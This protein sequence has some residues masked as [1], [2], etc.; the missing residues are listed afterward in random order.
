MKKGRSSRKTS[1]TPR[2]S[3]L[4]SNSKAS[5]KSL[6]K[7]EGPQIS[8][9]ESHA[10]GRRRSTNV[11]TYCESGRLYYDLYVK[12]GLDS[13]LLRPGNLSHRDAI[14]S[15]GPLS[16]IAHSS[17]VAC[18]GEPSGRPYMNKGSLE[19]HTKKPSSL[20]K[21][22]KKPSKRSD[23][24]APHLE[25]TT[26]NVRREASLNAAAKVNML[27]ES[28]KDNRLK[29]K[30]LPAISF[31]EEVQ[32][33]VS[34]VDESQVILP[35]K[36]RTSNS[37]HGRISDPGPTNSPP[38]KR[39][40]GLNAMAIISAF[41]KSPKSTPSL[42]K[43]RQKRTPTAKSTSPSL[44]SA[45][46]SEKVDHLIIPT[47]PKDTVVE[48]VTS[49]S[50]DT[51]CS[52]AALPTLAPTSESAAEAVI[53]TVERFQSQKVISYGPKCIG[54]E[55]VSRQ[56]FHVPPQTQS[57][58]DPPPT[59]G[60][61]CHHILAPSY[62]ST[63]RHASPCPSTSSGLVHPNNSAVVLPQTCLNSPPRTNI[64]S[65]DF[66]NFLPCH[67]YLHA[68]SHP[69]T[70]QPHA[71]FMSPTLFHPLTASPFHFLHAPPFGAA[72]VHHLTHQMPANYML[73]MSVSPVFNTFSHGNFGGCVTPRAV[74]S[75]Q[76]VHPSLMIEQTDSQASCTLARDQPGRV[77]R[78]VS[79]IPELITEDLP[80]PVVTSQMKKTPIKRVSAEKTQAPCLWT[81]EGKPH[82]RLVFI[83]PD[84]PPVMRLCYPSM[85]HQKD[86]M[87]VCPG[88]NVLLCSGPDRHSAPHVAKVTAL[89]TSPETGTKMMAL[90]W[91][92]RPESLTPPRRN[93][94]IEC[95]LFA[96]RHCDV[97]PVDCIDDR[98]YVLSSS[99]YARFMALAKYKQEARVHRRPAA[100][101]PQSPSK[102]PHGSTSLSNT[103][104][105]YSEFPE[106]ASSSNVFLCRAW[107]DFRSR[108]VV[109]HLNSS[110]SKQLQPANNAVFAGTA[111]STVHTA[112]SRCRSPS[113]IMP[114][115][116]TQE[117]PL[118]GEDC[119]SSVLT[120]PISN[121]RPVLD[122][123]ADLSVNWGDH[124]EQI[125]LALGGP[126]SPINTNTSTT[127]TPHVFLSTSTS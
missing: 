53:P 13:S 68:F 124:G 59:S 72:Y 19:K 76:P 119:D 35:P 75:A 37:H 123:T 83:K 105:D 121:G 65:A 117:I 114:P 91:Y 55:N 74:I 107:Y 64:L 98:A 126:Q 110:A 118:E 104:C 45:T 29:R 93:G 70:L 48:S 86:G 24:V 125:A 120:S 57:S 88:D 81:W 94:V 47:Q 8:Y 112:A 89:F 10:I 39:V 25:Q 85:R 66:H 122:T 51:S 20:E 80:S 100:V 1:V 16:E 102:S 7:N 52:L 97:N 28:A 82:Q 23:N 109:R 63:P 115:P 92:Y 42:V 87:V 108:R 67:L 38:T 27:F 12:F 15:S 90:L 14:D 96:S 103:N 111:S 17:T 69:P 21:H 46:V 78:A 101:V 56:I 49:T 9:K 11:P 113:P 58:I 2:K 79:P 77:D 33:R 106:D 4:K 6:T 41:M 26:L 50:L 71:F 30:S 36:K 31:G 34:P 73:P 60:Q 95:E 54:V 40:A 3:A 84:S 43:S 22:T 18:N 44:G 62:T 32:S 99:P 5:K 116:P 127:Q 61:M